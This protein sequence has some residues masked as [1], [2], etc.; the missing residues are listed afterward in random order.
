MRLTQKQILNT[1]WPL[2]ASWLLMGLESPAISAVIARL[3]DP[4]IH[5]A[6]YGGIVAPLSFIIEAPVIML[7]SASTALCVD[8]NTY[9]K[10]YRF[11]MLLGLA[12]TFL[13][14]L[15]AFTPVYDFIIEK[16]FHSPQEI[17][18]P[19]RFGMK[20][21]IPWTWSIGYRRFQQGVMIRY[22]HSR[23]VSECT[24]VRLV[25]LG[26]MLFLGYTF[27]WLPGIGVGAL[28]QGAAVLAE[29][30]YAGIRVK[31]IYRFHLEPVEADQKF[32]WRSF[33]GFYI[34]LVLTSFLSLIWSPLGSA[35]LSR[36]P[37]PL[38]SLAVWQVISG[39]IFLLRSPGTAY[40]EVVVSLLEKK[41][42]FP[43]LRQFA[44]KLILF[45]T[46]AHFFFAF[47]LLS[48]LWLV[49][50]TQIPGHLLL[51]AVAG[52]KAAILLPA[53]TTLVSWFQG[54]VL[55]S[56]HTRSIPE[57]VVVFLVT[58][59][60]VLLSG[61]RWATVPG[62]FFTIGGLEAGMTAQIFWLFLRNRGLMKKL[63]Q[64]DRDEFAAEPV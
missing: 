42:S 12:L 11:M 15:I 62:V 18:E 10:I 49:D 51:L 27:R 45:T 48:R 5:L 22:N 50:I 29:A 60:L 2:A 31:S 14:V 52:L 28:A 58:I 46:L 19:A 35:A 24:L 4:S 1:W 7:L 34:P 23:A 3:D 32:S 20:F 9:Q 17:V 33:F 57:S 56:R 13:H 54:S 39:L 53:L 37:R 41:R 16:I 55:Y 30:V 38:E 26:M 43:A 36:M 21:M 47:T 59:G 64:R 61:I 6:A 44:L 63:A 40:N 25:T 8:K